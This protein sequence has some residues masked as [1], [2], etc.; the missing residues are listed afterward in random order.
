MSENFFYSSSYKDNGAWHPCA[1]ENYAEREDIDHALESYHLRAR[2]I[3]PAQMTK[4]KIE[5][6]Y[7]EKLERAGLSQIFF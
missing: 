7:I 5:K 1:W 4:I 6:T 2:F 3:P